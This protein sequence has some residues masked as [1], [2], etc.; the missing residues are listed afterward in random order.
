MYTCVCVCVCIGN[1]RQTHHAILCGGSFCG[2]YCMLWEIFIL[3][4]LSQEGG[5]GIKQ[6]QLE[7]RHV[8]L[9]MKVEINQREVFIFNVN[10]MSAV[11]L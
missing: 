2:Q 11:Q 10:T 9:K 5:G 8:S 4:I 3:I 1:D 7:I 6:G